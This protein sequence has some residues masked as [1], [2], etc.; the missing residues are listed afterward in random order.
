MFKGVIGMC[1]SRYRE[2]IQ[3]KRIDRGWVI[4][5]FIALRPLR[6]IGPSLL[7]FNPFSQ[8]SPASPLEQSSLSDLSEL[9]DLKL[10]FEMAYNQGKS[11]ETY[12]FTRK[13]LKKGQ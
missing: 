8:L 1:D 9:L 6:W 7:L 10:G 13:C 3:K 4:C 5:V 11:I 2:V 12:D